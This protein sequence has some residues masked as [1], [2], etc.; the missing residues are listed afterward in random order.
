MIS[1]KVQEVFPEDGGYAART[2]VAPPKGNP[3]V[4]SLNILNVDYGALEKES[5]SIKN[6]F[7]EI[8]Q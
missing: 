8:F 5:A 1:K 7:N 2:D 6:K 3:D 4:K